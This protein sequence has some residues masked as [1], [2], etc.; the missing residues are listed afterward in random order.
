[1]SEGF[2]L[3]PEAA[4]DITGIWEFIDSDNPAAAMRV[5]E[6]ILRAIRALVA[7][8]HQGHRGPDLSN[9]PLRFIRVLD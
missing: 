1:M 9:R 2:R 8:P 3:H 7:F 6:K 5:R 4:R